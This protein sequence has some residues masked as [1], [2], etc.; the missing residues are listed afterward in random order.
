MTK[1]T[2]DLGLDLAQQ[3]G[4][5]EV[6]SNHSGGEPTGPCDDHW[7]FCFLA[8]VCVAPLIERNGVARGRT[9]E[10]DRAGVSERERGR[11]GIVKSNPTS[12]SFGAYKKIIFPM[13]T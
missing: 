1:N 5:C 4:V 10:W 3:V 6:S 7:A 11:G 12:Q 2:Q 13:E 9:K 8:L